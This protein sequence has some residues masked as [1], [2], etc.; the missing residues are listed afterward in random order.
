PAQNRKQINL[1]IDE[2]FNDHQKLS[3]NFTDE[4]DHSDSDVSPWPGGY[5]GQTNR[6]PYV[7]TANLTSTLSSSLLNEARFGLR[8][9]YGKTIPPW[10]SPDEETRKAASSFLVEGGQGFPVIVG[11]GSG[12]LAAF[13]SGVMLNTA[14]TSGQSSPLW[15]Y[16][17]TISWTKGKHAYK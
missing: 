13:Q 3:V 10:F 6:N 9:S 11:P 7:I 12:T 15:T 14:Q 5:N 17:D 16:A 8:R 4:W 1:K 2:N